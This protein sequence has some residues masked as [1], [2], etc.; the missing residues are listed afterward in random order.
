VGIIAA[1]TF[2]AEGTTRGNEVLIKS[3]TCGWVS[4]RAYMDLATLK[5]ADLGAA[6]ALYIKTNSNFRKAAVYARSCYDSSGGVSSV[7]CGSLVKPRIESH[8]DRNARCPF[9]VDTCRTAALSIDSGWIDTS[10]MLGINTRSEDALRFR[11]VLTCAPIVGDGR[12]DSPWTTIAPSS[13]GNMTGEEFRKYNFGPFM[14]FGTLAGNETFYY[15]KNWSAMQN[16]EYILWY[17]SQ[18][19]HAMSRVVLT[20]HKG[21]DVVHRQFHSYQL[22]TG[23]CLQSNRRRRY[24]SRIAE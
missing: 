20:L 8:I 12:F 14:N 24:N 9:E 3:D 15:K 5:P 18:L 11:K 23:F 13:L 7:S 22:C 17:V 6:D 16:N 4:E 10:E 21:K 1:G 2:S 19:L